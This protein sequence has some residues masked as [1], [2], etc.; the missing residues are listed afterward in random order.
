MVRGERETW[1]ENGREKKRER[2][3]WSNGSKTM[4]ESNNRSRRRHNRG[5]G[6][7]YRFKKWAMRKKRGKE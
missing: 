7:Q 6:K 2:E 5:G 3:R 1:G 4:D